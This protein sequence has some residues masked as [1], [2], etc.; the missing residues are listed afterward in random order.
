MYSSWT[1]MKMRP[2]HCCE[3]LSTI[4]PVMSTTSQENGDLDKQRV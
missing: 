4:H 2:L 3:T 1:V